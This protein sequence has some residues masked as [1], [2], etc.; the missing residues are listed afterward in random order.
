MVPV[1]LLL[2]MGIIEF[3]F[4]FQDQLALTHAAREGARMAS[5]GDWDEAAVVSRSYPIVPTV[6]VT[7]SPPSLADR[8][9]PIVVTL[10]YAY[11]WHVL[12]FPGTVPLSARATMRA[13]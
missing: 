11:D 9:D 6:S 1:L 8:G 7:P 5:V 13:E 12:P 10:T 4:M 3:G 2:V